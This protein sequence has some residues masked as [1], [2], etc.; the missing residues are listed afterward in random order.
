MLNFSA[1]YFSRNLNEW[2]LYVAKFYEPRKST[3]YNL[4]ELSSFLLITG[5]ENS[6][7]MVILYTAI[8][9]YQD[10]EELLLK[11][12]QEV[13]DI[14]RRKSI[15]F[16][17]NRKVYAINAL[18]KLRSIKSQKDAILSYQPEGRT[19][20]LLHTFKVPI[21]INHV[22]KERH[23]YLLSNGC[24]LHFDCLAS[25]VSDPID[26]IVHQTKHEGVVVGSQSYR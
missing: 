18:R 24:Q 17:S 23:S 22:M 3:Y 21:V 15:T 4:T 10:W 16:S 14:G 12:Q 7:H 26:Q 11:K 2:D 19:G 20:K 6:L 25:F 13:H 8:A 9:A 5:K 1:L